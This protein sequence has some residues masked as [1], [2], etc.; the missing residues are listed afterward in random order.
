MIAEIGNCLM[1]D[2]KRQ[3]LLTI[4]QFGG[5]CTYYTDIWGY[6]QY[7]NW[8]SLLAFGLIW[9]TFIL[10]LWIYIPL[11]DYI[12]YFL[13]LVVLVT[14]EYEWFSRW[15]HCHCWNGQVVLVTLPLP[16]CCS[17]V[18]V[19]FFTPH[20]LYQLTLISFHQHVVFLVTSRTPNLSGIFWWARNIHAALSQATVST[21]MPSTI[22]KRDA[23]G[24]CGTQRAIVSPINWRI[25]MV[26]FL[27][28]LPRIFCAL[29]LSSVNC[30]SAVSNVLNPEA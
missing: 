19:S 8:S 30:L 15:G 6:L 1:R 22:P 17:S 5:S 26:G 2:S 13:T 14:E 21:P 28:W 16:P 18:P 23:R 29:I 20:I 9:Q 24:I 7:T 12:L 25:S 4:S 10:S 11:V 27:A 3:T